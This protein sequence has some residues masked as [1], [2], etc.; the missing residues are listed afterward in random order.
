MSFPIGAVMMLETGDPDVRFMPRPVEGAIF[1]EGKEPERL[2][3]D[4]Q[5]RLHLGYAVRK[6][7]RWRGDGRSEHS[8]R[9][10][11][12]FSVFER[13]IRELPIQNP[14]AAKILI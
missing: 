9:G 10:C 6:I 14:D 4:G 8:A 7:G 2:I 1:T 5:Q 13:N 11:M 3:Q 12:V